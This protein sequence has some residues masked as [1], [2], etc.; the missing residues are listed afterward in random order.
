MSW[1]RWGMTSNGRVPWDIDL[2][3]SEQITLDYR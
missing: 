2:S 3:E 1:K